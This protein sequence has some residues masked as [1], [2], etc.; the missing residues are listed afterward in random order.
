MFP[1]Y[2]LRRAECE[3]FVLTPLHYLSKRGGGEHFVLLVLKSRNRR[4]FASSL[5]MASVYYIHPGGRR[6]RYSWMMAAGGEGMG[7]GFLSW[8]H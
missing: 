6:G 7:G 5:T 3:A 8:A 4:Q 2:Y 1:V